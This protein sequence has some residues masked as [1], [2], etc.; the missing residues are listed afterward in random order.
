[1]AEKAVRRTVCVTCVWAGVDS[2]WEQEKLDARKML[3]NAAESHTSGAR[4]VRRFFILH[5]TPPEKED[6]FL[7]LGLCGLK[8]YMRAILLAWKRTKTK[9]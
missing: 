3:E 5:D 6:S 7:L 1:M 8:L 9:S 4:F 2:V